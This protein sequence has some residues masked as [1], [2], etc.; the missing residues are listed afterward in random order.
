MYGD[1]AGRGAALA[2]CAETAPDRAVDRQIEIGI[3]HDDDDVLAAHLQA[4]MLE[5]RRARFGDE[6]AY[7]G[8][9]R[10]ADHRNVFARRKRRAST[11]PIAADQVHNAGGH[12]SF[13]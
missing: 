5:S 2:G 13:G 1:A 12:S 6:P 9:T 3:L 7:R 11:R 10:E 8:R 4:A